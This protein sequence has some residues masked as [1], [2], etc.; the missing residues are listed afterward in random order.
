MTPALTAIHPLGLSLDVCHQGGLLPEA[1]PPCS[2]SHHT[3]FCKSVV[4][5]AGRA[6]PRGQG[7]SLPG[8]AS[9]TD[10]LHAL[11]EQ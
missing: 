4:F 3:C 7:C 5:A 2:A 1:G 8:G 6:A 9:C 11:I 10:V